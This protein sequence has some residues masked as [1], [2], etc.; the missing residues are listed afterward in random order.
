M[1][2]KPA[3]TPAV[4][5]DYTPKPPKQIQEQIA[6]VEAMFNPPAE[7]QEGQQ[8]ADQQIEGSQPTPPEPPQPQQPQQPQPQQ[9]PEPDGEQRYR[10]L[11]GRYETLQ[12]NYSTQGD[13]IAELERLITTLKVKGAEEPPTTPQPYEKPKFISEQEATEYGEDLLN[14]IGKRA[15]EEYFPEF[16]QLAQRLKR[17]ETRVDGVGT[18]LEK[19]Q[20]MNV[21]SSLAGA[22]PQWREINRDD[23]FKAWLDEPDPYS[24][25]KRNDMLQEAFSRH[26][27][28]RVVSFFRGFLEAVGHPPP[29]PAQGNSAPPL[30]NGQ[31]SGK[32]SLE[33]YAAPGR[34]RSTPQNL[35][36]DKPIY[37]VAWI[38]KFTADK[39][40]GKYRGREAD[41][42]AIE[43]DIFQAQHEGRIQ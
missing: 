16:D 17:L 33:D 36:P 21:Y 5:P 20:T 23:G 31:A 19:D 39:I 4:I 37:T 9:E 25:R 3:D 30:P 24:G 34:A 40:A 12:K 43:R 10:S 42:D 28:N 11:Q 1:A 8:P 7:G 14:V 15:K 2:K 26:E 22:V 27:G 41:A 35:P 6:A 32:P 29:P 38:A 13:R 18:V